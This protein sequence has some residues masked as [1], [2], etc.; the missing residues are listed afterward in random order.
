MK[1]EFYILVDRVAVPITDLYE[2]ARWFQDNRKACKVATNR[3]GSW[4]VSTD[5]LGIDH[6]F[7]YEGYPL[8]FETM[9]FKNRHVHSVSRWF[10]WLEAEEGH[11]EI[12]RSIPT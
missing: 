6:N 9:V 1:P 5:F 10:S 8:L 4:V 3:I 12:V 11:K 2:W 7:D